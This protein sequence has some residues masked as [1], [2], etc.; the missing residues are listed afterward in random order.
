MLSEIVAVCYNII[1]QRALIIDTILISSVLVR[2]S[3]QTYI[4]S[5]IEL[6]LNSHVLNQ[7]VIIT[8]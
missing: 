5:C 8:T 6:H 4:N 3:I 1:M 7:I 2:A